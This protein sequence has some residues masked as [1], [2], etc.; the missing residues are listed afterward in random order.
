M[1]ATC[2]TQGQLT[3]LMLTGP[4]HRERKVIW[5]EVTGARAQIM[6][7]LGYYQLLLVKKGKTETQF[8]IQIDKDLQRTYPEEGFFDI[9]GAMASLRNILVAYSCRNPSIGYC[10]GMNFIA[11]RLLSFGFSEEQAFWML[12]QILE[13]YLPLDYFSVMTGVLTDQKVFHSLLKLHVPRVAKHLQ[14]HG[15]DPSMYC[16]QWLVCIFAYSFRRD[17]VMRI[18]DVFFVEGSAFLFRVGLGL[19]HL[20]RDEILEIDSEEELILAL[21]KIAK[22]IS[23]PDEIL[24]EASL[25]KFLLKG[26]HIKELRETYRKQVLEEMGLNDVAMPSSGPIALQPTAR[27]RNSF[28]NLSSRHIQL[29]DDY[30]LSERSRRVVQV[31]PALQHDLIVGRKSR[32]GGQ[33]APPRRTQTLPFEVSPDEATLD[34]DGSTSQ[35]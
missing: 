26:K 6:D 13:T 32:A 22:M 4:T 25:D 8:T 15:I 27:R 2:L 31:A 17:I 7:N 20:L 33:R 29:I 1:T 34:S 35:E 24:L 30:L 5:M 18:W 12:A 19:M 9:P 23:D 11:G 14:T 16:V 21:E 3:N 10:Q 28:F